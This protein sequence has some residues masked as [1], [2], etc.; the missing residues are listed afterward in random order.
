ML[1]ED[2][3]ASDAERDS[4]LQKATVAREFIAELL[5]RVAEVESELEEMSDIIEEA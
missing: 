4:K 5:G 1:I 2:S 3:K